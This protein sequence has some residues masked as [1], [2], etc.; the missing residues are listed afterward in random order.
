MTMINL[1]RIYINFRIW[2][3]QLVGFQKMSESNQTY[4]AKYFDEVELIWFDP[5]LVR[6]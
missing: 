1:I 4:S 3:L 6:N 5:V 2:L